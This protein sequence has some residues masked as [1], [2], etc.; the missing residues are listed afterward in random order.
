MMCCVYVLEMVR[1][2]TSLGPGGVW[3]RGDAVRPIGTHLVA[4]HRAL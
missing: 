2:Q 3:R 4:G 1:L